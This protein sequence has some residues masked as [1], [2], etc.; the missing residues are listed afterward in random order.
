[1][2]KQSNFMQ[3][4]SF[5]I[6]KNFKIEFLVIKNI[7]KNNI[8]SSYNFEFTNFK[9]RTYDFTDFSQITHFYQNEF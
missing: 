5:S 3:L 9:I 7:K 4:P 6:L 8:S 1:M 2:T